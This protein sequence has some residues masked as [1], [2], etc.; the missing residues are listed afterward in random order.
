VDDEGRAAEAERSS[1]LRQAG[2]VASL[3]AWLY[4]YLLIWL[5]AWIL[6]SFALLGWHPVVIT[7]GSMAPQIQLG[8]VVM[9]ADARGEVEAG[10]V[11]TYP[12]PVRP[13]ALV[14]HRI[15]RVLEDGTYRTRGD[16]NRVPDPASVDPSEVLGVGRLL[17]PAIGLPA[18]WLQRGSFGLLAAWIA[19]TGLAAWLALS[20]TGRGAPRRRDRRTAPAPA[21]PVAELA[22]RC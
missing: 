17:V 16:A 7:G 13:G 20:P 2:P 14:T 5:G 8:D 18:A 4:L 15:D 12:D 10:L 6:V 22:E 21:H 1:R 11:I 9:L 19:F 3:L